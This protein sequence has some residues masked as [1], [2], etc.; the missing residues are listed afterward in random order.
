MKISLDKNAFEPVRAHST[1]AGLDLRAMYG[2]RVYAGTGKNF[3]T[4]V[5]IELPPGKAGLLVSKS[6]L[7]TKHGITSTGLIDE[8]FAGEIV[9]RLHNSGILDYD[10]K[11]GDKISQLVVFSVDYEPVEIVDKINENTERGNNGYGSTGR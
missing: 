8:G 7:N 3:R 9:V 4:G 11:A 5:H 2:G 1:D 10:V 6:G